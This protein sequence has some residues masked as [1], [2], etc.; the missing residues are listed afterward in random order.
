MEHSSRRVA[1]WGRAA[2]MA[3][4]LAGGAAAA[5]GLTPIE[6][7]GRSMFFDAD[8]S[9]G[10][11]QSCAACHG[12]EVGFTGPVEAFNLTGA[13][14]EGSVAGRFGNRKPPS[15]A[16]AAAS[17]ILHFVPVQAN[18]PTKADALFVG[19]NFWDGRATGE[20]LGNPAADQ[21]Q[22]PF[23]NPLEQ[24]LPDSACVVHRVCSAAYPVALSNVFPGAC[25]IVWP[26]DVEAACVS[27]AG[28]VA[29]SPADRARV[30]QAY[31]EIALAIAA[32]E[33]SAEV[34]AYSSKYD[35][36]LAGLA[37][38]SQQEKKGL[39][40][41][42]AKGKCANCHVIDAGPD[43]ASPLFTDHTFDNLGVPRNPENP[44]YWQATFNP[45]GADWL[46]LGLG[47]FLAG[48]LDYQ[49]YAPVN[50][51]K[52]KVPTLRNVDKRPYPGFVKAFGHNGYFKSLK[53]VV[54]FYNTRDAKP[55]CPDPFTTE[56]EAL[57]LGCWPAPEVDINVNDREVGNLHLTE[58][59]EDAIVAFLKTLS[60]GYF[61]PAAQ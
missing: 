51:G 26:A 14:Y 29:L 2:I 40:L 11:N 12:P 37:A 57:A 56:A 18:N 16:Y 35:A 49:P 17:P 55:A 30:D 33:D 27:D 32:Y 59:Q 50:L 25:D 48:R 47:A 45:L 42:R 3:S 53:G 21:A 60:D 1:R 61:D 7:L 38:L 52:Q 46:D 24:A 4:A 23:L 58:A 41:F 9:I 20:R 31:D 54:H 43:G 36:Y 28:M 39:N 6:T 22:G 15:A 19:G 34:S 10:R 13:V 8:L 44:F 5:G